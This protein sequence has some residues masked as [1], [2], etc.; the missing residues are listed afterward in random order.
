MQHRPWNESR[1]KTCVKMQMKGMKKKQTAPWTW[2]IN[3][4][5]GN[6][7]IDEDPSYALCIQCPT[8]IKRTKE[9]QQECGDITNQLPTPVFVGRFTIFLKSL[10]IFD[11]A[12]F[13]GINPM[14]PNRNQA[15]LTNMR[16]FTPRL[17]IKSKIWHQNDHFIQTFSWILKMLPKH[18]SFFKNKSF[19]QRFDIW[20]IWRYLDLCH[21]IL[22]GWFSNF[23]KFFQVGT[24]RESRENLYE[25]E[26]SRILLG[27]RLKINN[28]KK[29]R[30]PCSKFIVSRSGQCE[31]TFLCWSCDIVWCNSVHN[32]AA[33]PITKKITIQ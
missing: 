11:G 26:S 7:S 8:R 18:Q 29:H 27:S 23:F 16:L 21:I 14:P 17:K 22:I 33:G 24:R 10:P 31:K 20:W 4:K 6:I 5:F 25:R 9:T 13:W 32:G 30:S 1:L 15:A 3:Q 2:T 28:S 12:L 19:L